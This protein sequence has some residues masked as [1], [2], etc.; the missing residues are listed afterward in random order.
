VTDLNLGEWQS[1]GHTF[2]LTLGLFNGRDRNDG[3]VKAVIECPPDSTCRK[4][5]ADHGGAADQEPYCHVRG[6]LDAL[7]NAL[8]FIDMDMATARLPD[9]WEA[10]AK[11]MPIEIEWRDV[12]EDGVEW[13]PCVAVEAVAT[14]HV[15]V[16]D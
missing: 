10:T 2:S 8:D 4:W 12:G 1:D 9:D 16:E 13:R 11:D 6:E 7:G 5:H 14:A 15:R 3:M